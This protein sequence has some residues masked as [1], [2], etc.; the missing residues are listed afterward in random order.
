MRIKVTTEVFISRARAI[1]GN[2]Y[3]YSRAKYTAAKQ[4]VIIGCP[5]HGWFEQTPSNHTHK[6]YPKGC[7]KCGGQQMTGEEK[8]WANVDKNGK[9]MPHMETRCW[10]WTGYGNSYGQFMT[11]GQVVQAH[12][13]SWEL[14]CG[15]IPDGL[16]ILHKCDNPECTRPDHLFLGTVADNSADMVSKGRACSG[17]DKPNSKLTWADIHR[18]R[19]LW[20]TG[21]Y[22]QKEL[23]VIFGIARPNVSLIVRN[24]LWRE[25]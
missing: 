3:D 15:P 19:R 20:N 5:V 18:M 24:K 14:H 23:A 11:G 4:N 9:F 6:T 25:Q 13:F 21:K 12:R 16:H 8:F 22:Q 2:K 17:E 1:H 10:K 7:P